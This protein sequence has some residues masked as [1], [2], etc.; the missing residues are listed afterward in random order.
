MGLRVIT[1]AILATATV[2]DLRRREIPDVM[3]M[4]LLVVA[5]L[6]TAIGWSDRGWLSLVEGLSVALAAGGFLFWLGAFGG[7]DVKII[8][9]LG[10]VVGP[11]ALLTIAF[12]TAIAGGAIAVSAWWRGAREIPYLPAIT[13]GYALSWFWGL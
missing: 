6:A 5:V 13:A 12:Y 10:A 4:L 7:G 2:F 9:G 8:A 1:F 11:Q 3:P